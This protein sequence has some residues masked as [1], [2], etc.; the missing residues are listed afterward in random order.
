[1][2]QIDRYRGCLLG[3]A[4]GD[5]VG[6]TLEFKSPGTFKPITDMV[7]GGL[8]GLK[9][10]QWTDDTSMALCLAASLTECGRF[11][12]RDP[13]PTGPVTCNQPRAASDTPPAAIFLEGNG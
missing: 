8:F 11:D 2:D 9:P 10:G 12:E 3:L 1:M 13:G 7:G 4:I 5:A 6:S